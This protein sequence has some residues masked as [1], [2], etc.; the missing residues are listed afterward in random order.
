MNVKLEMGLE[1]HREWW[2]LGCKEILVDRS[3]FHRFDRI[4]MRTFKASEFYLE[5]LDVYAH[6]ATE[7]IHSFNRNSQNHMFPLL[8]SNSGGLWK[9]AEEGGIILFF[10]LSPFGGSCVSFPPPPT[11]RRSHALRWSSAQAQALSWFLS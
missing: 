2:K 7:N 3:L 6:K 5:I 8:G 9:D 11:P 10:I 4:K 1:M